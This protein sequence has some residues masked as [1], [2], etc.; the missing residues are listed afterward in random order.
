M[1]EY[2]VAIRTEGRDPRSVSYLYYST[3]RGI[4]RARELAEMTLAARC[5]QGAIIEVTEDF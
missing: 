4:E 1:T 2:R 3:D 5:W